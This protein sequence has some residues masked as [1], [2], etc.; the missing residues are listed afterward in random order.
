MKRL[1]TVSLLLLTC[2]CAVQAGQRLPMHK[3]A[4]TPQKLVAVS[5]TVLPATDITA[6]A[7][8]A[9]WEAVAGA[10]GYCVFVYEPVTA[11]S[12]GTYKV[13]DESFNLVNIGSTVEP[14]WD[15]SFS[16]SLDKDYDFTFT[17]DWTVI[18]CAFAKG[19]VSGNVYTPTT[20]LSNNGGKYR[21]VLDIVGQAG[22]KIKV[23]STG[24]TTET[25]EAVLT[26]HGGGTLT[27]DF[28]NGNHETYMYIV[29]MGI[30][31]DDDGEY[32]NVISFFDNISIE[33]ELKA[34]DTVLRLVDINDSVN[35]PDTSCRFENMK[36]LYGATDL[37]YDLYAAYVYY[38]DY[39]D[40]WNY[41]IDYSRFSALQKVQLKSS[42]IV[43]VETD[44][45]AG[46]EIFDLQGRPAGTDI[47]KLPAGIYIV[48]SGHTTKKIRI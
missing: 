20:D 9:N 16:C 2:L 7:F 44:S 5:P 46:T 41:D 12:D 35:A 19:M 28:T 31:G 18:G 37:C 27:F 48:R 17:P 23:T 13:L 42:A 29:D 36:F 30:E 45:N 33:Q 40:P 10:E 11:H 21:L 32:A 43:E 14:V 6:D 47:T 39:D 22:T 3:K 1:Y 26:Q 8:T 25:R 15:E 34:G 4:K 38:D 24:S